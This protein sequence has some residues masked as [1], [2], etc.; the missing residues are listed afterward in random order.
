[1]YIMTNK[2]KIIKQQNLQYI[3]ILMKIC[4]V[5]TLLIF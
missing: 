1:M 2:A 4:S 5:K 3:H